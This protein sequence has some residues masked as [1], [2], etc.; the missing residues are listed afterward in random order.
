MARYEVGM[1]LRHTNA[2]GYGCDGDGRLTNLFGDAGD[3]LDGV[4]QRQV[5]SC[6]VKEEKRRT[7]SP[8][9]MMMFLMTCSGESCSRRRSW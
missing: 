9:L 3:L 1:D 8:S 6:S 7:T 5:R 2:F 4:L